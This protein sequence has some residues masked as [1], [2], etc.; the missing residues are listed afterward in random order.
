MGLK[1]VRVPVASG[2][3]DAQME[4]GDNVDILARLGSL[5]GK[6]FIGTMLR[7]KRV[8]VSVAPPPGTQA[9]AFEVQVPKGWTVLNIDDGG[10]WDEVHRTVKC[11]PFFGEGSVTLSFQVR[12]LRGGAG[13]GRLIGTASF[14]GVNPQFC[15]R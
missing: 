8:V 4:A 6:P 1:R 5:M 3:I 14:D 2:T 11:G 10:A 7:V 13:L 9:S 15:V 12:A